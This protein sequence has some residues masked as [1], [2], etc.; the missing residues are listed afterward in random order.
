V[1]EKC[2]LVTGG[3]SG[4]GAAICRLLLADGYQVVSLS[5]RASES[6]SSRLHEVQVDLADAL[7]TR[8]AAFEVASRFPIT[9][10]IH[11]AGAIREKP[12]EEVT[13]DDLQ[14]L[15]NLHLAAA[16]SLMQANL[17]TMKQR[18]FGRVVLV[19][20]RAVLGLAKR[21]V[22]SA[23]KAG[24]LGLARTWAL[25]LGAHGITVN[26]VAPGPI[27]ATEMFH[28]VIP[29]DSPKL[30]RIV[31]SIPVK[32]LGRP[33]DV[34]RA[35]LFFVAPDA[36]FVTGQTLFVCGGTSVGSIVY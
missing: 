12:L 16:L 31:D 6:P 27:E 21:T 19:S 13:L 35:V 28:D 23:T 5:R 17:P 34:A 9:T 7:A 14:S 24:M 3:S 18:H 4:I 33:E 11:N 2:A 15:T 10:V 25:E 22:Y 32:R 8:E 36:G 26:V 1:V 20:T 29:V 30:P